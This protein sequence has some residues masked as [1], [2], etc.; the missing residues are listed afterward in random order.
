MGTKINKLALGVGLLAASSAVTAAEKPNI[1]AI[2]GDDI[3]VFNISAYNN[4]MMG[5]ET[6]TL[7]VSLMKVHC[8]LTTTVSNHVLR[9]VLHS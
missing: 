4:G 9:V 2:W 6:P 3:G 7:T 5:Y 1:L 8:L